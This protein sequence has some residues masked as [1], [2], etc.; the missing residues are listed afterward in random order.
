MAVFT[1]ACPECQ[2]E[3]VQRVDTGKID[4]ESGE[5]YSR[6]ICWDCDADF[7]VSQENNEI[8]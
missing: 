7:H 4:I 5:P 6:W 3:N 1:N 8:L 2:G